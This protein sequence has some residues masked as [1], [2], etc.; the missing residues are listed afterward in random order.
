[1]DLSSKKVRGVL[2]RTWARLS[3]GNVLQSYGSDELPPRSELFSANQMEQYGKILAGEH[4]LK[5]QR[6][7]EHLLVRLADNER[8]LLEV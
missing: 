6:S 8:V 5:T 1:M 4:R 7:H 3:R 2:L